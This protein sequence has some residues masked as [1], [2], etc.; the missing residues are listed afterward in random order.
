MIKTTNRSRREIFSWSNGSA[1]Q[2]NSFRNGSKMNAG[3]WVSKNVSRRSSYFVR[4]FLSNESIRY[5][6]ELEN[7]WT[8]GIETAVFASARATFERRLEFF[9]LLIGS[10]RKNDLIKVNK[11]R[12]LWLKLLFDE[13]KENFYWRTIRRISSSSFVQSIFSWSKVIFRNKF[14]KRASRRRR[15][16]YFF[17]SSSLHKSNRKN[18][19]H[20]TFCYKPR[21]LKEKFDMRR[22]CFFVDRNLNEPPSVMIRLQMK[23]LEP[24]RKW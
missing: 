16:I 21:T 22:F 9:A 18:V 10:E 7:E 13:I 2:K 4:R 24:N 20:K 5:F 11:A 17:H 8:R 14:C 19:R 3:W 12:R 23:Q 1:V 6:L 15:R